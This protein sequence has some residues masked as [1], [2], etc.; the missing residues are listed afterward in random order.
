M[1]TS[2]HSKLISVFFLKH[3]QSTRALSVSEYEYVYISENLYNSRSNGKIMKV[4]SHSPKVMVSAVKYGE[5]Y[6]PL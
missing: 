2:T 6:I 3:A 5:T 4:S 1:T